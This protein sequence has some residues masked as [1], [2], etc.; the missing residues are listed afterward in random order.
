MFDI[1]FGEKQEKLEKKETKKPING[2]D[3]DTEITVKLEEAYFGTEKKLVLRAVNE[4]LFYF[5]TSRY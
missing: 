1:F 3:I 4:K 5:N 2:E